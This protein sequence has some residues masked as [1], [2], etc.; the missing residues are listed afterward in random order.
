MD[1]SASMARGSET[2]GALEL[3]ARVRSHWE[4]ETCGVRYGEADDRRSWFREIA[5]ARQALEPYIGKFA[6]FED[7]VGKRVLEI[8][9]GAGSDFVRWCAYAAHATGIDLTE[10]G[11]ALARER[12]ELEGMPTA[13]YTLLAADAESLP[14]PNASLILST[15]GG[16]STTR[17]DRTRLSRVAPS[18]EARRHHADDDLSRAVVDGGRALSR[19]WVWRTTGSSACAARS[20]SISKAPEPRPTPGPGTCVGTRRRVRRRACVYPAWARRLTH[21]Q[22]E[23]A[24]PGRDGTASICALPPTAG[25]LTRRPLRPLPANRRAEAC[26]IFS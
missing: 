26:L 18:A 8:G 6:R 20:T 4:Q 23:S 10:A 3:K 24:V 12:L 17:R 2:K 21:Y 1:V 25:S 16:C 15:H 14:F 22:A 9:V 11:I 19:P 5:Q 13:R 7:S